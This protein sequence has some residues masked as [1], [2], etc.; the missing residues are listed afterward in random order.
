MDEPSSETVMIH[1]PMAWR[2]FV[3]RRQL[4]WV[5]W[6]GALPAEMFVGFPLSRYFHSELPFNLIGILVIITFA[7]GVLRVRNWR[8][9]RCGERF[10]A[11]GPHYDFFGRCCG[12]CG[13][14]KEPPT[15]E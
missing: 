2:D 11:P 7:C 5:A 10:H 8:C 1:Y 12:N 13:L 4:K 6:I 15:A 14:R 3:A 9:P